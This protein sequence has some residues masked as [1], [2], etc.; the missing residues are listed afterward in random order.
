M[1]LAKSHVVAGEEL[2]SAGDH[3]AAIDRHT[4][5]IELLMSKLQD[6]GGDGSSSVVINALG[7]ALVER[8]ASHFELEGHTAQAIA[9]YS[10]VPT[11]SASY[12]T[13]RD[14]LRLAQAWWSQLCWEAATAGPRGEEG[15]EAATER[16]CEQ[17]EFYHT[18]RL[19]RCEAWPANPLHTMYCAHWL[20]AQACSSL[21]VTA[22]D[23]VAAL[24]GWA[25]LPSRH[26]HHPTIDIELSTV[27]AL[28]AWMAP[29]LRAVLLPALSRLFTVPAARIRVREI[30][31]V[32]YSAPSEAAAE[33][34]ENGQA[35]LSLHRDAALLSFSVLLSDPRSFAGGG[36][37][38]ESLGT[39]VQPER[40]GD[41]FL[42]CGQ[43]RHGGA[44]VTRGTRY[45]IVAFVA[46]TT[47]K[48]E[49]GGEGT[50][51]AASSS[52]S[53]DSGSQDEDEY[54]TLCGRVELEQ[55]VEE[56]EEEGDYATL[57]KHWKQLGLT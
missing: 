3:A 15:L 37:T 52:S 21:I 32:K 6:D 26:P 31:L 12:A 42:H 8:A 13:A 45:L 20:T 44:A 9:D 10:A 51:T 28:H 24:G 29:R 46:V 30:F 18:E 16:S 50:R 17:L 19:P 39:A 48:E 41:V 40:V 23:H 7:Y 34:G 1:E 14:N 38:I 56:E 35:G 47:A 27:P 36:T 49:E 5:A 53:S 25:T 43:L 55:P 11:E 2:A 33:R 4:C 54:S 57:A 22:E